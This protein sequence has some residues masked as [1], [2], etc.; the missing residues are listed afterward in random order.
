VDA[1]PAV[2]QLLRVINDRAALDLL[3]RRGPLSRTS[4]A[5]LTGLSHPTATR[6]LARLQRSGLVVEAGFAEGGK[7]PNSRL[8]AINPSAAY[9]AA[10]DVTPGGIDVAIADLTGDVVARRRTVRPAP[11]RV[12]SAVTAAMRSLGIGLDRLAQVVVGTPG[13]IDPRTGVLEYADHLPG[14]Q[15]PDLVA[16]L[17]NLLGVDVVVENDVNLAALAEHRIGAAQGCADFALFWIGEGLGLGVVMDG[18]LRR[19][20]TGGAGEVSYLPVPGMAPTR[21]L[22]RVD[23]GDFQVTAGAPAL[24]ELA[25]RHG[26]PGTTPAAVL[27]TARRAGSSLFGEWATRIAAGLAAVTCVLDPEVIVIGGPVGTAAGTDLAEP[28]ATELAAITPRAPRVVVS[29]VRGNAVQAGAL[30]TSLGA[31][32]ERLFNATTGR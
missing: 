6:L 25:R 27:R 7:G 18:G 10:L 8:Y 5:Q 14:W 12:R 2:P 29:S 26:V 1:V 20:A 9:F 3:V 4:M 16:R 28:L 15:E 31:G 17:A 30:L 19:G 22:R 21:P 24:L 13:S 11:A 23:P 32:R